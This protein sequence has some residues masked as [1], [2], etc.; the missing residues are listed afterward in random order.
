NMS[1]SMNRFFVYSFWHNFMKPFRINRSKSFYSTHGEAAGI[2][3]NVIV[4]VREK[5]FDETR[6]LYFNIKESLN[7]FQ[8]QIWEKDLLNP[9]H[10]KAV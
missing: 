7:P 1:N 6:M 10:C 5:F 8:Q 3:Q 9:L 4:R 2:D